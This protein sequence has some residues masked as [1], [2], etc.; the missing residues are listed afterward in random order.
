MNGARIVASALLAATLGVA[1]VVLVKFLHPDVDARDAV[2][3][4]E[5]SDASR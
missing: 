4:H 3:P 2:V 5:H 1:A